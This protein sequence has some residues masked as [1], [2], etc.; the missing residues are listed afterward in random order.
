MRLRRTDTEAQSPCLSHWSCAVSPLGSDGC[1]DEAVTG[2]FPTPCTA[3]AGSN[4][5]GSLAR[6]PITG[7][8]NYQ[9]SPGLPCSPPRGRVSACAHPQPPPL[10]AGPRRRCAG[11]ARRCRAGGAAAARGCSPCCGGCSSCHLQGNGA[12]TARLGPVRAR[13]EPGAVPTPPCRPGAV[14]TRAVPTHPCR[15]TAPRAG[16]RGPGPGPGP[17]PAAAAA[18]P[19]RAPPS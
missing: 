9:Q 5:A 3:W 15:A 19:H 6:R 7:V 11:T 18:P 17:A 4:R 1:R 16:P 8:P 14:P 12:V 2:A 10:P 13:C